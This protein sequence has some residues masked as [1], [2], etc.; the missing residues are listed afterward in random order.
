[1]RDLAKHFYPFYSKSLNI[2]SCNFTQYPAFQFEVTDGAT[3]SIPNTKIGIYGEQNVNWEDWN[4][5][6]DKNSSVWG[7]DASIGIIQSQN[8]NEDG[9][10]EMEILI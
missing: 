3:V 7:A 10:M 8:I 4:T 5:K 2:L 6:W 9:S 1:M